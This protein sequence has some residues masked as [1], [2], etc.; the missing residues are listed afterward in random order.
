[1]LVRN[2]L[3]EFK[4][5][6]NLHSLLKEIHVQSSGRNHEYNQLLKREGSVL[7]KNEKRNNK[8]RGVL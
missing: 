7:L 2:L 4:V 8:I 1:M 6:Q 5:F 3:R